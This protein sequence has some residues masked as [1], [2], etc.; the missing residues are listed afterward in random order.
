[1]LKIGVAAVI[2]TISIHG[3]DA[4][5]SP[6]THKWKNLDSNFNVYHN[7]H[8]SPGKNF[9]TKPVRRDKNH[10]MTNEKSYALSILLTIC[11]SYTQSNV[12]TYTEYIC[13]TKIV[14]NTH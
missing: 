6:F 10:E 14:Q 5:T 9:A 2:A 11:S 12:V 7:I 13:I 4:Y 8:P 3:N 1:M